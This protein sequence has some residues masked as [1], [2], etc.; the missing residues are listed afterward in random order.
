MSSPIEDQFTK[1]SERG[2]YHWSFTY[3]E[4]LRRY[5][6]RNHARYDLPLRLIR[7]FKGFDSEKLGL[8]IGCGDGVLLYKAMAAGGKVIGLDLS[9]GGLVQ[10]KTEIEARLDQPP[11][12]VNA[13]CYDLPFPDNSFDY[14]LSV[15]VIEHLS[16]PDIYLQEINRVLRRGGVVA[17]TTPHRT[18]SGVVQDPFHVREYTG[19]ELTETLASH[20]SKV[21]VWGMYPASL[22]RLYYNATS[23][24]VIDKLVRGAFK[25]CAKC[26]FNPYTFFTTDSP[27]YRWA[28]LV[29]GTRTYEQTSGHTCCR[30]GQDHG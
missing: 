28:N 18:R 17:L 11:T 12:L 14:V 24:G 6:P 10:G 21:F 19:P 5:D 16:E 30:D 13:S 4:R 26:L 29:A 15:E 7:Q 23:V 9:F 20:F 27:D 22:D 25:F 3:N 2:A 1:Y 8:D